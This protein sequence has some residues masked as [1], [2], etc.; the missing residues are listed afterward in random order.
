MYS[1]DTKIIPT[2]T[3]KNGKVSM[4]LGEKLSMNLLLAHAQPGVSTSNVPQRTFMAGE[5]CWLTAFDIQ[6]GNVVFQFYSDPYQ[7][8]RYQGQLAIPYPK[9]NMPPADEMLKTVAE[10]IASQGGDNAFSSAPAQETEQAMAPIAAP[11]PPAD[12]LAPPPKTISKGN[13]KEQVVATFRR[14][15]QNSETG[16]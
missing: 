12:Q 6:E 9:H 5:K 1:I 14:A 11:P 4:G 3:Y 2:S 7:D 15:R 13:T 10:V 8:V 16:C